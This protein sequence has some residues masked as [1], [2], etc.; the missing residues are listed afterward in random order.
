M[1]PEGAGKGE[2]EREGGRAGEWETRHRPHQVIE[3]AGAASYKAN[4]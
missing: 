2:R 3:T 1:Q 4:A